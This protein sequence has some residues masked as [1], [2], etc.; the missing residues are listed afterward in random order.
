MALEH[1]EAKKEIDASSL[2]SRNYYDRRSQM[3]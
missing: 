1:V 2:P 3:A